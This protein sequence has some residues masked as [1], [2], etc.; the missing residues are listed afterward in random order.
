[1]SKKKTPPVVL[2]PPPHLDRVHRWA[3]ILAAVVDLCDDIEDAG[4]Q[5]IIRK[6]NA[7]A[8]VQEMEIVK[9]EL[10]AGNPIKYETR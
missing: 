5:G 9:V 10:L 3:E 4:Q 6:D 7:R 2:A 1:M 8:A